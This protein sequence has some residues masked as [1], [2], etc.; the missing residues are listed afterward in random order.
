MVEA[1]N[2]DERWTSA[3]H[4]ASRR[5]RRLFLILV[6]VGSGLAFLGWVLLFWVIILGLR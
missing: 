1:H 6:A 2:D 3:L 5:D 4:H